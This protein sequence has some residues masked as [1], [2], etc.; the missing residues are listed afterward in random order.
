MEALIFIN[1][2]KVDPWLLAACI[3]A[4]VAGAVVG[5]PIRGAP[6]AAGGAGVVGVA[7]LVAAAAFVAK[8]PST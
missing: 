3:A 6:A 4:S 1:L 5:K 8:K 7:L 2:V